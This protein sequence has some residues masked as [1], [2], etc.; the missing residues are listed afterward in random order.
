MGNYQDLKDA[1]K[2]VIKTNGNEE[3]TGSILQNTLVTIVNSVGK[4]YQFAG[5]ANIN[6]NPGTPDEN[7]FYIASAPGV[8]SNFNSF[9]VTDQVLIFKNIS[10]GWEKINTGIATRT[11]Y[12][13]NAAKNIVLSKDGTE[14]NLS[15]ALNAIS[16]SE[17]EK[18]IAGSKLIFISEEN[19]L[20]IE[21]VF[22]GGT[23]LAINQWIKSELF[24]FQIDISS[25]FP[26]SGEDGGNTYTLEN[27]V[28]KALSVISRNQ[29]KKGYIVQYIDNLD[30]L[31]KKAVFVGN[32]TDNFINTNLW[33]YQSNEINMTNINGL[34]NILTGFNSF[35]FINGIIG[36][37]TKFWQFLNENL[38][39]SI[40]IPVKP[41]ETYNVKSKSTYKK[42][43]YL[44][45]FKPSEKANILDDTVHDGFGEITI[46]EGCYLLYLTA[47]QNKI[48]FP[49][50]ENSILDNQS[51]NNK[52]NLLYNN[53]DI[54]DEELKNKGYYDSIIDIYLPDFEIDYEKDYLI[55]SI[56]RE[57]KKAQLYIRS[58]DG[59]TTNIQFNTTKD[60]GVFCKLTS[61]NYP[62]SYIIID[63]SKLNSDIS[64]ILSIYQYVSIN[65]Y[66]LKERYSSFEKILTINTDLLQDIDKPENTFSDSCKF[67]PINGGFI[68]ENGKLVESPG[69]SYFIFSISPT[70]KLRLKGNRI[71][72]YNLKLFTQNR[73]IEKINYVSEETEIQIS[74]LCTQIAISC[75]NFTPSLITYIEVFGLNNYKEIPD[76]RQYVNDQQREIICVGSST[77]DNQGSVPTAFPKFMQDYLGK[78]YLVENLG[79]SGNSSK[80]INARI[81]AIPIFVE[82]D[83]TIPTE[84]KINIKVVYEDG[85][86]Y[87]KYTDYFLRGFN[88][89]SINGIYGKL[90]STT[91]GGDNIWDFTRIEPGEEVLIKAKTLIFPNSSKRW[92]NSISVFQYGGNDGIP[93]DEVKINNLIKNIKD[94]IMWKN[95]NKFI[96]ISHQVRTTVECETELYKEFGNRLINLRQILIDYGL[97]WVNKIAT[98]EDEQ[99][100]SEG[101]IPPSLTK[102]DGI[103]LINELHPKLAEYIILRLKDLGY[104]IENNIINI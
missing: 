81:G 58:N 54:L 87:N 38:Y 1:I 83:V 64:G 86:P 35:I 103:H 104:I 34:S 19:H 88:P 50:L 101:K 41:G 42:Y 84:G 56:I 3:I 61:N 72:I 59:T 40:V 75:K 102:E 96:L 8:Y 7:I 90:N 100:I 15:T 95:N 55:S 69:N 28:R 21:Y 44:L 68:D 89:V 70:N 97:L 31:V 39:Y 74:E 48:D 94:G 29:R 18:I 14:Y 30:K 4:N 82:E 6:T 23:V 10:S 9:E 99:A 11:Y 51:S 46:P 20:P 27:A 66:Y 92:R 12:L 53:I 22:K 57:T 2:N 45:D 73:F 67:V 17:R 71:T 32:E 79:V 60:Y 36:S 65:K 93:D 25:E 49:F 16:I 5:V 47:G 52:V 24:Q 78:N 43:A 80:Q 33:V 13:E 76:I 85:T 62:N 77:T 63:F 26:T 91:F 37:G 98:P